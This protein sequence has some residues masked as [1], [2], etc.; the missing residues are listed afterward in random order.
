MNVIKAEN[1][2]GVVVAF[3]GQTAIKLTKFLDK[4]VLKFSEQALNQSTLP[5]TEN[6]LTSFWKI[7]NIQTEGRKRYDS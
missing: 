1:P 4:K 2:I 6:V 3:G 7:R 5:R